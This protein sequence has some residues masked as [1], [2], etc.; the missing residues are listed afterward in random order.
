M[1]MIVKIV[2]MTYL[3]LAVS[4]LDSLHRSITRILKTV[5]GHKLE[6][7]NIIWYTLYYIDT[8]S[9]WLLWIQGSSTLL[10]YQL[11]KH[12]RIRRISNDGPGTSHESRRG[13]LANLTET[14]SSYKRSGKET[15]KSSV[16]GTGREH[17]SKELTGLGWGDLRQRDISTQS[18]EVLNPVLRYTMLQLHSAMVTGWHGN[19]YNGW[20][21]EDQ[22]GLSSL[23]FYIWRDMASNQDLTFRLREESIDEKPS[24]AEGRKIKWKSFIINSINAL[25]MYGN[26]SEFRA[27]MCCAVQLFRLYKPSWSSNSN[28]EFW[29]S[30]LRPEA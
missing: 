20:P 14:S 16:L 19:H 5:G 1:K 17:K 22:Q 11:C 30:E 27:Q 25:Q 23:I 18:E 6:Y 8:K 29:K 26:L 12:Q 10:D 7:R 21:E 24:H 4:T 13:S 28:S 2:L 3:G 15:P 9:N